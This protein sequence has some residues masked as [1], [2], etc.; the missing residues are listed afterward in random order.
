MFVFSCSWE[1]IAHATREDKN[2]SVIVNTIKDCSIG[3]LPASSDQVS[4]ILK[5]RDSVYVSD[6]VVM[7]RERAVIQVYL[8]QLVMN[9]LH[10]AQ[11]GESGIEA[12][13]RSLGHKIRRD[14]M[15][16]NGIKLVS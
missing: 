9:I 8:R 16:I 2:F 13:A 5:Y 3:S 10:S 15:Q 14:D 1:D 12:R 11:Q 4:K 6:R 7:Y